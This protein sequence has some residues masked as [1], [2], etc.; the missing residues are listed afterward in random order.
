[1]VNSIIKCVWV[2]EVLPGR[3]TLRRNPRSGCENLVDSMHWETRF[4]TIYK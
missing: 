1:M 2:R 4:Q 3:V